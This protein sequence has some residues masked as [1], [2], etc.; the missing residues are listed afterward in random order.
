MKTQ[1]DCW[2]ELLNKKKLC[3]DSGN[4]RYVHLVDGK[5]CDENGYVVNYYF[6]NPGRWG[7]YAEPKKPKLVNVIAYRR[8]TGCIS[9]VE[10]GSHDAESYEKMKTYTRL[11]SLDQK[12]VE[13]EE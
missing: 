11:P 1:A 12:D 13:V 5:L 2:K 4:H 10:E 8:V 3:D 7:I 6:S 9:R